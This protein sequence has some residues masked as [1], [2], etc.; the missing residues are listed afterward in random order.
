MPSALWTYQDV[1]VKLG[2]DGGGIGLGRV[3]D[4]AP[5]QAMDDGGVLCSRVGKVAMPLVQQSLHGEA[6]PLQKGNGHRRWR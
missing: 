4:L 2:V 6:K 1:A 3:G 5:G